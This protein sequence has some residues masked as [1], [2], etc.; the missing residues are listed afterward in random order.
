MGYAR[1]Q[2]LPFSLDQV[3]GDLRH[4]ETGGVTFYVGT[5]R[6][7][8]GSTTVEAL[9]YEA[10]PEMA[11]S[12]LEALRQ[13]TVRRFGLVDAV[14]VHRTGRLVAGEPILLVA[15]AGAHRTE[16]FD[17]VRFFMD[18]LKEIVPI[19][20]KEESVQGSAWILGSSNRRVPP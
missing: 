3:L 18:R 10:F 7:R 13:E 1:I 8:E 4:D 16:T 2:E 19:W 17:A 9:E 15:L 12:T 20:K 14:V 11:L 6:R 5:V